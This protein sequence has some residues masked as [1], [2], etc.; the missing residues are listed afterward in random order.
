MVVVGFFCW[1]LWRNSCLNVFNLEQ[2]EHMDR[3][4]SCT[5][6]TP[7]AQLLITL[8]PTLERSMNENGLETIMVNPASIPAGIRHCGWWIVASSV[9]LWRPPLMVSVVDCCL[10]KTKV[11]GRGVPQEAT[12]SVASLECTARGAS[13]LRQSSAVPG[14]L[15]PGDCPGGATVPRLPG[16]WLYIL[17][18]VY[19][20]VGSPAVCSAGS[21]R[22]WRWPSCPQSRKSCLWTWEHNGIGFH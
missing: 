22:W 1:F 16:V 5:T 12:A 13:A 10:K 4:C 20:L 8:Y 3:I 6:C 7:C 2:F 11:N 18:P 17:A 9:A 21:I 14:R 19:P 15:S